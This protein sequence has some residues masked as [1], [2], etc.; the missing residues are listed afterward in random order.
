MAE[1]I[2]K[3]AT[4]ASGSEE[5]KKT[6]SK[7]PKPKQKKPNPVL[8]FFKKIGKFLKE[9]KSELKKIS[10]ASLSSTLR[11]T[12]I[13]T[14]AIVIFAAFFFVCDWLFRDI[15]IEGLCKIPELIGLS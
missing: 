7:E 10:W 9:C 1:D 14:V 5:E 8:K 2:K 6:A 3:D 15:I 12:I 13:V 4:V 11:N